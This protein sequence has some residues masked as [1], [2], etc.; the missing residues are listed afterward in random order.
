METDYRVSSGGR[1]W[2]A[3]CAW[4]ALAIPA[5]LTVDARI[6]AKNQHAQGNRE[7]DLVVEGEVQ[8]ACQATCPTNA[9]VFGDLNDP[10]SAVSKARQNARSYE[11]LEGLNLGARTTYL[12]KIRNRDSSG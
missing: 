8:T 12:A 2:W 1:T 4:D 3:N 11:L 5:A 9:I 6:E 10:N 7:S